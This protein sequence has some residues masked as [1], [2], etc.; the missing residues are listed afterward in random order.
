[1]SDRKRTERREQQVFLFTFCCNLEYRICVGATKDFSNFDYARKKPW[2]HLNEW[3]LALYMK[4]F[5][6][7]RSVR[8][9]GNECSLFCGNQ[10][11]IRDYFNC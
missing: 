11:K 10:Y 2:I 4:V 3:T 5:G 1:M 9:Y 8:V 6:R 7:L